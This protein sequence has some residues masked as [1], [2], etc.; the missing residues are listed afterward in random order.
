[1]LGKYLC[2]NGKFLPAREGKVN[3]DSIELTY[4]FGVYEGLK[5]RQNKVLFVKE[6]AERLLVSAKQINL[7]HNFTIKQIVDWNNELVKK[8]KVSDA[9]VKMLLIGGPTSQEAKLYIFLLAPRFVDK[10]IYREGTKALVREYERFLPQVKSLNMLPSYLFFREAKEVGA[11]DCLLVNKKGEVLEGTRSNFYVIKNKTIYTAPLSKILDGVTR[12]TVLDC[13]R[14][15]GYKIVERAP[16]LKDIFKY[17]G[18]FFTN[19]SGKIVP[20]RTVESKKYKVKSFTEISE[21]LRE[22]IRFYNQYLE[23]LE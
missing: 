7:E 14:K 6:H 5:L 4:G 20:I 16:Q 10:K 15:N 18:A 23:K 22:L 1:M 3:V 11:F 2:F 21:N 12:R 8:N 19:T 17:D 9:H 13:A